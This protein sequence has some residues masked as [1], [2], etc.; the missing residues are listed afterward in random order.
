M[1]YFLYLEMCTQEEAQNNYIF[2]FLGQKDV[3][4]W[5]TPQEAMDVCL[6]G[7]LTL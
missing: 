5:N 4:S 2:D 1:I 6:T 3:K 7:I